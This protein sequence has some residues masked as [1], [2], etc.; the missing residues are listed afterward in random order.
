MSIVYLFINDY[1]LFNILRY[2]HEMFKSIKYFIE[3]VFYHRDIFHKIHDFYH[4]ESK[5]YLHIV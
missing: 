2:F 3:I 1:N 5:I 4:S